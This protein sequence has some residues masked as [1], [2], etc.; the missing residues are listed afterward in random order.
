MAWAAI[1]YGFKSPI[2]FISYEGDGK[3]FTQQKYNDQILRGQDFFCVEDNS[4]V[5]GKSDTKRNKGLCN[6]TRLEVSYTLDLLAALLTRPQ[7]NREYLE[8]YETKATVSEAT[9]MVEAS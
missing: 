3:G 1:G 7:S 2:Y 8:S 5:H 9:R 6:A 4:K